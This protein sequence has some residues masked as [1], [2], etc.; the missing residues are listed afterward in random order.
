MRWKY[1]A[2]AGFFGLR[3]DR[4]NTY[5]PDR[6]LDEKFALVSQVDGLTGIELKY[7]GDL[8]DLQKA[9]E[10]LERYHLELSAVNVNTKSVEHFR[11]G[12][13]SA[14]SV[15]ARKKTVQLLKEGM[16]IAAEMG[17][18]LVSTC[19]A[20][21]GYDYPF[22]MDYSEAWQNFIDNLK[23]VTSHR[24]DVTLMLEYQPRDPNAKILLNNVGKTL[25]VCNEVGASNLGANLDIG[26]SLAASE[27]P[28][29]SAVLLNRKGLLKYIHSNDNTGDGGDWDMISGTVHFWH[30]IELIYTL[31]EMG[32]DGWIGADLAPRHFGPGAAFSTNIMMIE[33]M[34]KLIEK[35]GM[36]QIQSLLK[37]DG[38][39]PKIYEK[40]T[41][42]FSI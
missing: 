14:R 3:R 21:D 39:T 23:S 12:S 31:M 41:E 28:A 4:F 29:E 22:Q 19:P 17:V 16:D 6:P 11:H 27:A 18:N 36:E 34:S 2:N 37:Q 42:I 35:A 25:F 1:S 15:D 33:R 30:W 8:D 24:D 26:H 40:L 5:Q 9:R 20:I 13:W 7:P 38:N 10:L 32:Y